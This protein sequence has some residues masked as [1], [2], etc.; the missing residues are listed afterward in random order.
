MMRMRT[1]AVALVVLQCGLAAAIRTGGGAPTVQQP[2][3][4]TGD[5]SARLAAFPRPPHTEYARMCRWL[6][7]MAEWGTLATTTPGGAPYGGVVSVSDG[8]AEDPTGRLLFYLTPMDRT[9]QH[10]E[11][12]G[13][14][15]ALVLAEAS[16]LP[17]GCGGTDPE[18]PVC[19]RVTALGRTRKV[20]PEGA[21]EAMRLLVARHPEMADWPADHGF[22][23]Y[24]MEVEE[25]HLLDYFGGMHVVTPEEYFSADLRPSWN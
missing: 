24:E 19:A 6:A 3:S 23:P 25:I 9:T 12:G 4:G 15:S 10:L 16:Q 14:A 2:G 22:A 1:A 13:G 7:H 5:A 17:G 11:A 20:A 18:S 21:D 8:P